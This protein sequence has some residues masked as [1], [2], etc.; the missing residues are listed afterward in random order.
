MGHHIRLAVELVTKKS[1]ILDLEVG[2][3]L[4]EKDG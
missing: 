4:A 3:G 2:Q 1:V